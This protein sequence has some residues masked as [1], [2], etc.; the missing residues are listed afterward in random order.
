MESSVF[1]PAGGVNEGESERK[2]CRV[3]RR[4]ASSDSRG[5]KGADKAEDA[6]KGAGWGG[7]LD[8]SRKDERGRTA[9]G[10]KHKETRM[11]SVVV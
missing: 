11:V 3:M 7:G 1:S 6:G 4:G 2:A 8:R 9:R 5:E 10:D